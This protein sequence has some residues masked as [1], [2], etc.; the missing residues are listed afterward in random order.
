MC[1][2]LDQRSI[3]HLQRNCCHCIHYV[4]V[5]IKMYCPQ[6]L[7]LCSRF[8]GICTLEPHTQ[9]RRIKSNDAWGEPELLIF[10]LHSYNIPH[11]LLVDM[12]LP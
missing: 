12:S 1:N 10:E 4:N 2:V 6:A 5:V 9:M 8:S 7:S 11:K 3:R